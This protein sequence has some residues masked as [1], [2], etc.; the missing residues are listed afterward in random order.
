MPSSGLV[1]GVAEEIDGVGLE[2]EPDVGVHRRRRPDV[3][4]AQQLLDDSG[5]AS[6]GSGRP[7]RRATNALASAHDAREGDEPQG[8][9]TAARDLLTG[10]FLVESPL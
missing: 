7:R 8:E 6:D 3:G 1:E 9:S 10:R 5:G 2:A 4:V